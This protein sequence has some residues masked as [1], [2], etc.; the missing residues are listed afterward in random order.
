[1]TALFICQP[2]LRSFNFLAK[3]YFRP[4]FIRDIFVAPSLEQGRG[5]AIRVKSCFFDFTII[6]AYFPP[7]TH[8]TG[9]KSAYV[10]SFMFVQKMVG[11]NLGQYPPT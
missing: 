3:N 4:A 11:G 7:S 2:Q 9:E 5:M 6:G 1:M 10:R 8:H